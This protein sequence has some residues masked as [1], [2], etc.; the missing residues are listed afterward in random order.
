MRRIV[1]VIGNNDAAPDALA[2]AEQLGRG[3]VERGWR[4]AT[5]GLGGM[6]EAASRGARSAPRYREGDV[7]GILPSGERATANRFVD[8]AI[9]TNM[10]YARNVLLVSMAD[11]VVAVGG[12]AGTLTEI[13]MAWQMDRALVALELP[14][15]SGELAGRA[16]D[17]R[18][19]PPVLAA[20]SAEEAVI[21]LAK[22]FGEA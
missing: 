12:G 21:A 17:A 7:I 8:I 22:A 13:A 10:G 14:G 1:A 15:W 4:L 19:R 20:S 18:S 9:P 2:I 6:M 3:I 16:L 11:A 5:G